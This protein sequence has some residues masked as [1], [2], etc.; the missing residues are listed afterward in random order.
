MLNSLYK[1][2]RNQ[3]PNLILKYFFEAFLFGTIG[4]IYNCNLS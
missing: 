1:N 2:T 3:H 4:Y